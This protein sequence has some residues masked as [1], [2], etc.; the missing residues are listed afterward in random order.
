MHDLLARAL[1]ERR[2]LMRIVAVF[3]VAA[4]GLA[5]LGLYAVI[6]YSVSQRTREIG[7]RMAMGARQ[8]DVSRLVLL[9]GLRLTGIGMGA[10]LLAGLSLAHLIRAQIFG[11]H[12]SDPATLLAAIVLMGTTSLVAVYLPARR[13][14]RVDPILALRSER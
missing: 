2:F 9:Q 10:G 12:P 1:A 5:L 4:I 6:S 14:A 13:A 3:G 8:V 11:V 7:I